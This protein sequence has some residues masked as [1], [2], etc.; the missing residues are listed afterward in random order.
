MN[1]TSTK[2]GKLVRLSVIL[3]ILLL[4]AFTPLGYLKVGAVE[5]SF[6]MLPVVV[7]AITLGPLEGLILG[8]AFGITSFIQCL[9]GTSFFGATLL[10]IQ[11]IYTF[12][13]CVIPRML[14]GWLPGLVFKALRKIKATESVWS[15]LISCTLGAVLNTVF[16][17]GF[18]LVLFGGTDYIQGFGKNVWAIIVALTGVNVIF[19]AIACAVLG[20]PIT[21]ALVRYLP[22]RRA[23]NI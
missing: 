2:T 6:L 16:F 9:N 5:I 13:L 23:D 17:I 11:P 4:L 14:A 8:A 7:G 21:K 19:E 22:T 1:N 20:T 12:I 15:F 3:A 18:L 10:G